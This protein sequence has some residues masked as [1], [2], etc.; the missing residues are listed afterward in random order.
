VTGIHTRNGKETMH[1]RD[2]LA[3]DQVKVR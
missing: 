3:W 2:F 1:H